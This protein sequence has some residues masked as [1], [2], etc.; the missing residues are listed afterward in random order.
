MRFEKEKGIIINHSLD[1][2]VLRNRVD[3]KKFSLKNR[4]NFFIQNKRHRNEKLIQCL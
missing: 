2:L 3:L 1:N 4:L